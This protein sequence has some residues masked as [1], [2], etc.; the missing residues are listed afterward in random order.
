MYFLVFYGHN[1]PIPP[2][3]NPA[4]RFISKLSSPEHPSDLLA[5]VVGHDD[6]NGEKRVVDDVGFK[7]GLG[8]EGRS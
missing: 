8:L 3:H 7:L 1:L 4:A 2:D 5:Q 6:V